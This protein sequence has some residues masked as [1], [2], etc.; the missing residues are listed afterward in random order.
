MLLVLEGDGEVLQV[1]VTEGR[2][3]E[4]HVGV[5]R[6]EKLDLQGKTLFSRFPR[7]SPILTLICIRLSL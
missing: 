1:A 2:K 6:V 4:G 3:R 7:F 5:D